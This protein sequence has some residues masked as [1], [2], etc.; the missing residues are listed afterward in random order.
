MTRVGLSLGICV[1][2]S[3]LLFVLINLFVYT[4]GELSLNDRGVPAAAPGM[5]FCTEPALPIACWLG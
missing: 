5:V 3:L 2:L 1:D 4:H